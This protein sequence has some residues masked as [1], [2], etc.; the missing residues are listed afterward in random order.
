MISIELTILTLRRIIV[1]LIL[2]ILIG[3]PVLS[4]METEE[5]VIGG[6][7]GDGAT[8]RGGWEGCCGRDVK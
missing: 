4:W 6:R 8:S 2:L 7:R 1:G 5:E 3:D